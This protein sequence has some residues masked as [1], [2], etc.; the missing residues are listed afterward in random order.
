MEIEAAV[1]DGSTLGATPTFMRQHQPLG[2]EHAVLNGADF[3]GDNDFV[4]FLGDN[5]IEGGF[6]SWS[7]HSIGIDPTHSC[8]STGA[9]SATVRRPSASG[10]DRI[11]RLVAEDD[12]RGNEDVLLPVGWQAALRPPA[13]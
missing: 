6:T 1:G 11:E 8:C 2:L 4:M 13:R 3:L 10:D 9:R 5:L 7:W 12:H